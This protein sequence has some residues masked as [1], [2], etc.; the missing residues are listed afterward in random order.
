MTIFAPYH[1]LWSSGNSAYQIRDLKDAVTKIGMKS[2]TAAFII[3]D[4]RGNL[5]DQVNLSIP[6][7]KSFV[8]KGN[9]LILSVGG[10][11]GPFLEDTLSEDELYNVLK[12]LLEDTGSRSLDFDVEGAAV[13]MTST[14]NK[15]NKAI[16]RLQTTFKDLYISYTLAVQ[17]PKWGAFPDSALNLL[18]DA[19][20]EG[21]VVNVVNAMVMDLYSPMDKSWGL[22]AIDILESM[23]EQLTKIYPDKSDTALYGMLGATFMCGKND[24]PSIFNLDDAKVLTA[25]AKEKKIGLLSYWALQRDQAKKGELGVSSQIDQKDFDFYNICK[26]VVDTSSPAPSPAPLPSP[27]PSP[28]PLPSPAPKPNVVI[29]VPIPKPAPVPTPTPA[30]VS[31]DTWTLG[32]SYQAGDIVHY[33]TF[34]YKCLISHNA[35]ESW[36][37]GSAPALWASLGPIPPSPTP[38]TPAPTPAPAPKPIPVPVYPK[39]VQVPLPKIPE[40]KI[41]KQMKMNVTVFF[42]SDGSYSSAVNSNTPTYLL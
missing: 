2:A 17:L 42:N 11:S 18:K 30:P 1:Y 33:K 21:V 7:L 27:A 9:H 34:S 13:G 15:R 37:P 24:D 36:S 20:K 39:I 25:F 10:A 16:K 22:T 19:K 8:D 41:L 29:P 28:A 23:R 38:V 35:I 4:G 3:G 26:S 14:I 6:D 31:G 32:K 5:W 40:G 12:K